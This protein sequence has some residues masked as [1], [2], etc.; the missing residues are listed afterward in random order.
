MNWIFLAQLS[1][2]TQL[3]I[4]TAAITTMGAVVSFLF[5]YVMKFVADTKIDLKEC[6]DDRDKLH[7]KMHTLALE[8]GK[9]RREQS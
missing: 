4:T 9:Y 1:Q 8:V 3:G 2:E 6:K 7:D 5:A